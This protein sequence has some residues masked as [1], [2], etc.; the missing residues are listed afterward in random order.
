MDQRR[1]LCQRVVG[2]ERETQRFDEL[3]SGLPIGAG[4]TLVISGAAGVG[5][6]ALLRELERRAGAK[7]IPF[8]IGRCTASGG[9]PPFGPFADVLD[10]IVRVGIGGVT[11]DR[12]SRTYPD[13]ARLRQDAALSFPP[14]QRDDAERYRVHSG[15]TRLLRT[16]AEQ[17]PVVVAID[18]IHWAD[19]GTLELLPFLSSKL[20][21]H[22]VLIVALH[23]QDDADEAGLA[24]ALAALSRERIAES[25]SL[26]PLTRAD[27]AEMVDATLALRGAAAAS[28][29]SLLESCEGNPFFIEEVLIGLAA[30]SDLVYDQG[31]WELA[32]V[33]RARAVPQS[34]R[35]AVEQRMRSLP[36]SAQ[37][38]VTCAAVIGQRSDFEILQQV[39]GSTE[40]DLVD[41]L[42]SVIAAHLLTEITGGRG[43]A[44]Y[45]FRHALTRESVL[46]GMLEREKELL[47]LRVGDVLESLGSV[48]RD[49][50]EELAYHFDAAGDHP[51]A[52]RYHDLAAHQAVDLTAFARARMHLERCLALLPENDSARVELLLR[53]SQAVFDLNDRLGAARTCEEALRLATAQ[54][55]PIQVAR[56]LLESYSPKI[57][58]GDD[59][60]AGSALA[61][62]I[63]I[64]EPLGESAELATAYSTLAH[65]ALLEDR[66]DEGLSWGRRAMQMARATGNRRM[67]IFATNWVGLAL[68]ARGDPEGVA[69]IRGAA[70]LAREH[71][72]IADAI[73]IDLNLL[74]VL[75]KWAADKREIAAVYEAAADLSERHLWRSD[76]LLEAQ[77]WRAFDDAHWDDLIH[78]A[79][80]ISPVPFFGGARLLAAF[81][82]TARQGPEYGLRNVPDIRRALLAA[83]MANY[84][85]EA[86]RSAETMLLVG[87]PSAALEHAEPAAALAHS[88]VAASAL[89]A[90]IVTAVIAAARAGDH[91]ARSRW[92]DVAAAGSVAPR[93]GALAR[94]VFGSAE[95]AGDQGDLDRALAIHDENAALFERASGQFAWTQMQLRRA[96]LLVRRGGPGDPEAA[97]A[98]FAAVVPY[99]RKAGATWY[100]ARLREWAT[101]QRLAFPRERRPAVAARAGD[102]SSLTP[103][104]REVAALV[105]TGMTNRQIA[106]RLVIA[107]RTAEGHVERIREKLD[108][109]S[110]SEIARW[111]AR[112]VGPPV[113]ARS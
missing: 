33:V 105:S 6:T 70:S 22:R 20:H 34:V 107:E 96:E 103:R 29:L 47:H 43:S 69:A 15:V 23:R 4:A 67:E 27:V 86:A 26:A 46:A 74:G 73:R 71:G 62:A 60:A 92:L 81:A 95:H 68:S 88:Y 83:G 110:R 2:R 112:A 85:A 64:L 72:L 111:F 5:K 57:Q 87:D 45:A 61:G 77:A 104:E 65:R 113:G 21:D 106:D 55:T 76:R 75:R 84:V 30:S 49:R 10:S 94:R 44:A 82:E 51:R 108:L 89:D 98:V 101:T 35:N 58:L 66:I 16:V 48:G 78:T 99:W 50:S 56:A 102:P 63:E 28:L 14:R 97:S 25:M 31:R 91:R 7:G 100:L 93:P 19:E 41:S 53:L 109:H 13:L 18:D 32:H 36:P 40:S 39:T 8:L 42:R 54:G 12:L 1:L 9:R 38:V 24:H 17:T 52:V 59:P 3:L 79:A 80:E 37:R 11:P 90:T